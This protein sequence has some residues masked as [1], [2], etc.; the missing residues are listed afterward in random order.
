[1]RGCA[2]ERSTTRGERPRVAT[3]AGMR[4]AYIRSTGAAAAAHSRAA[5]TVRSAAQARGAARAGVTGGRARG[6]LTFSVG[7]AAGK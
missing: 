1:M 5:W 6:T 4:P 7:S 3:P 2:I